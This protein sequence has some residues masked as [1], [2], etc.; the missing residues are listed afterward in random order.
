MKPAPIAPLIALLVAVLAPP[1][2]LA[3]QDSAPYVSRLAAQAGPQSVLLTWTDAPGR[4]GSSYEVWRSDKEILKDTLPQAKL[5]A[6]VAAGV[7]AYEDTTV[8]EPSFYL[9]LVKDPSGARLGYYIP[10][11]NKT[12]T[13]VQPQNDSSALT[14][15]IKVGTVAYAQPQV[16]VAFT[17]LPADR[18]LLVFRRSDPF[19]A[20]SD[21]KDATLLGTTTGAQSPWKD[22]PAPGLEFYYAVVDAKAYADA[23]ADSW[24][25]DNATTTPAGFPLVAVSAQVQSETLDPTLRPEVALSSRALP[26]PRLQVGSEPDSGLAMV[27]APYEPV[28]AQALPPAS[29]EALRRWAKGATRTLAT[30][31]AKTVLP[32]ERAAGTAGAG[33]Y[34]VKIQRAYFD[35]NDWKGAQVALDDVLKLALDH[36][37]ESR[38]RFYR[39]ETFAYQKDYR[40]AFVEFLL[41]R[42]DYPAET[43]PF[44]E[45]LFSLLSATP[46]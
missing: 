12:T 24:G 2:P 30:L 44:L 38:A 10:F 19:A 15:R 35:G 22:T 23:K 40:R 17:A 14:A 7:E 16:V 1:A 18:K 45:A 28:A 32:E 26:L 21:L 25:P 42:D 34:L 46:E 37:T 43:Q 11:R 27:P 9:V 4:P 5:L 3:A 41:A 36:K 20:W 33:A 8:K 39:A 29:D 13:P 31:P 6:T